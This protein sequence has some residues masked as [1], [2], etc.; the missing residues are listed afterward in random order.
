M[1]RLVSLALASLLLLAPSTLAQNKPAT[2]PTT[3]KSKP[4]TTP[5]KPAD[6][7]KDAAPPKPEM[8][9]EMEEAAKPGSNHKLL[10]WFEGEWTAE[11]TQIGQD[12]PEKGTMTCKMVFGSRFLTMEYDGR[13]RGKFFRGG[14]Y[15]GYNNI[16]KRFEAAWA[17]SEG[18]GLL[19]MTGKASADGKVFTMSGEANDPTT[20]K[21]TTM[22]AVT[23]ITGKDSWRDEF[24]GNDSSG[25][26]MVAMTIVYTRAGKVEKSDKGDK[27]EKPSDKTTTDKPKSK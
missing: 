26:E 17:D 10:E 21:R 12:K 15:W 8:S 9:K 1:K 23:T 16:E 27:T 20:G 25:K 6:K 3:D 22:K 13:S 4:T 24:Y 18:T 11:A 2:P 7:T 5:S 14:G 19:Y